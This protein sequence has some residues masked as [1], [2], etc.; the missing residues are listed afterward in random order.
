MQS[1]RPMIKKRWWLTSATAVTLTA[2][3][4]AMT[5]AQA[6]AVNPTAPVAVT[7]Q[8]AQ[9]SSAEATAT[10]PVAADDTAATTDTATTV[11]DQTATSSTE[12]PAET[13]EQSADPAEASTEQATTDSTASVDTTTGESTTEESA[14]QSE[15][16][17]VEET[18]TTPEQTAPSTTAGSDAGTT[19]STPTANTDSVSQQEATPSTPEVTAPTTDDATTKPSDGANVVAPADPSATSTPEETNDAATTK[20]SNGANL[21]ESTDDTAMTKPSTGASVVESAATANDVAATKPMTG[22]HA[23]Q[24]ANDPLSATVTTPM[25]APLKQVAKKTHRADDDINVWMPNK[26]LQAIILADLQNDSH[27][28]PTNKTWNSVSD[29]T[30]EDMELLTSIR[31]FTYIDGKTPFSLEGLQYAKNLK[32]IF[33]EANLNEYPVSHV[34]GDIE[35]ISQL[36]DLEFL[37]DVWLQNNR[38]KDVTPLAGKKHLKSL[39]IS[40]NAISDF[41][42][43]KGM[44]FDEMSTFAGQVIELP[45][46]KVDK[47]KKT[48]HLAITCVQMDGTTVEL[49]PMGAKGGKLWAFNG[50]QLAYQVFYNGGTATPDG[51]GGLY[52]TDLV[53]QAAGDPLMPDNYPTDKYYMMGSTGGSTPDFMV[54]QPYE[55]ADLGGTVTVH[56]VDR[57]GNTLAEDTVLSGHEVGESYTTEPLTI[58]GYTLQ[59][60]HPQFSEGQYGKDDVEVTYVYALDQSDPGT[61]DNGGDKPGNG[62]DTGNGNTSTTPGGDTGSG[63]PGDGGTGTPGGTGDGNASGGQGGDAGGSGNGSTGTGNQNQG[64][65]GD[66]GNG[67]ADTGSQDGSGSGSGNGGAAAG[68]DNSGSGSQGGAQN[69]G[70]GDQGGSTT[71]TPGDG[72]VT[73]TPAPSQPNKPSQSHPNKPGQST[74]VTHPVT[75]GQADQPAI[76]TP[77]AA[78]ATDHGTVDLTAT[79]AGDADDQVSPTTELNDQPGH[80]QDLNAV[81]TDTESNLPQTNGKQNSLGVLAGG[82]ML[83]MSIL[84]FGWFKRRSR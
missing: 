28:L 74:Q 23:V 24:T 3:S 44:S 45:K 84:T 22:A 33:L 47:N 60:A 18:P 57:E 43:L 7:S 76:S 36:K 16:N 79:T 68:G 46:K 75:G 29:I 59:D 54:V 35:D 56:Y 81:S 73:V 2:M 49:K 5:T 72:T 27:H 66:S 31:G 10:T 9:A 67:S 63:T 34:R 1:K 70:S 62:G 82:L 20:P 50:D 11:A 78:P 8:S 15:A 38:I 14:A 12:T 65:N 40:H 6:D 55:Y 69:G 64:G 61:G 13:P 83:V 37:E 41:S 26:H 21:V 58:P 17:S 80:A 39:K 48:G 32:D 4:L 52:Y 77:V 53:A 25:S 42:P 19:E 30:K 51:K 71:T